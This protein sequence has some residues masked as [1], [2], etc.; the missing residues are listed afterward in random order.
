MK[1]Q[2]KTVTGQRDGLLA[3]LGSGVGSAESES[4]AAFGTLPAS[5]TPDPNRMRRTTHTHNVRGRRLSH[6][7]LTPIVLCAT[8]THYVCS[9]DG[10]ASGTR[11]IPSVP[12]GLRSRSVSSLRGLDG[13][14][15]FEA[16]A[17]ESVVWP[18][19]DMGRSHRS[20][21]VH[22]PACRGRVAIGAL[23]PRA[24]GIALSARHA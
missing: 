23:H 14:A 2:L 9:V 16:L 1:E 19:R 10:E 4:F 22:K 13:T 17:G 5:H 18:V 8:V 15:R 24:D 11:S 6:W 3:K 21:C 20:T 12:T 7:G